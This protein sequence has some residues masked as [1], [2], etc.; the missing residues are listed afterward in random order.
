MWSDLVTTS[1]NKVKVNLKIETVTVVVI[2]LIAS[3]M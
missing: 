2:K 1:L 3:G